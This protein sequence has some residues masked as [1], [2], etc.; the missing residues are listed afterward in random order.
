M[1]VSDKYE[2]PAT[3]DWY[4]QGANWLVGL[5]TGAIAAGLALTDKIQ[6]LGS[7]S[8]WL[9]RLAGLA[10]LVTVVAGVFS[11]FFLNSI[12]NALELRAGVREKIAK[13]DTQ[14]L[15][16]ELKVHQG[17]LEKAHGRYWVLYTVC[18]VA[19]PVGVLFGAIEVWQITS[20]RPAPI[21][22]R[23]RVTGVDVPGMAAVMVEES[24][25]EAWGL[26]TDS[27]S[28]AFVWRRT[29]RDSTRP[30]VAPPAR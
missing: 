30:A 14:A 25:A 22:Q 12:G 20:R 4:R 24:S 3:L 5:S 18:L 26:V 28:R 17:K 21:A 10:F 19:F 8:V 11:Y 29:P 27:A 23:W 6:G 16:D 9:L 15:Q 7:G 1:A 13:G 2:L